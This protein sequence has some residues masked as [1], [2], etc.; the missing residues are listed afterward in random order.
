MVN[1]T[2]PSI[3]VWSDI[4][5]FLERRLNKQ[6]FDSWFKPIKFVDLDVVSTKLTLQA[7]QVTIDWITS[8]YSPL[9]SQTM[10]E[11]GMKDF[12]IEWKVDP[13]A[14]TV[15]ESEEEPELFFEVSK[16]APMP[17]NVN[18][19]AA[20]PAAQID[21]IEHSLNQKYTFEKFVVG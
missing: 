16:P 7:G 15:K 11:F 8:Y 2:L 14:R 18:R 9:L 21:P 20:A 10:A 3:G 4:Q 17:F 5:S 12:H 6:I 19:S 1:S 13:T